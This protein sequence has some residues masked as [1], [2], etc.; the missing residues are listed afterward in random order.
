VSPLET[1]ATVFA[2]LAGGTL[3]GMGVS[4]ALPDHH[5]DGPS[6]EVVRLGMGVIGTMAAL[7]L[8]LVIG[9]A[10]N[11]FDAESAA[12]RASAADVLMLDR[13]LGEY[14]PETRDARSLLQRAVAHRLGLLDESGGAPLEAP[15]VAPRVRHVEAKIRAL[16]PGTDAQRELRAQALVLV[17]DL[18]KTR[19]L[20]METAEDAIPTVF[21]VM[22]VFWLSV[23]FWS[24]GLHAPR[25]ATVVVVLLLCAVS[26]AASIFVILEMGDPF[27][28]LVRVSGAPLRFA[29]ESLGH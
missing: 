16:V 11:T 12:L 21:L 29:L 10:R 25:N 27:T 15:E 8:G 28:G 26:V 9:D 1:S 19:W 6:K 5:L 13:V 7:V 4:S 18:M 2:F 22:L 23:L 14:G 20:A 24:F 3:L 17:S